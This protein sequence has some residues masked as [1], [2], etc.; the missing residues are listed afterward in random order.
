MSIVADTLNRLQARSQALKSR[1]PDTP[2][3]LGPH[4]DSGRPSY[5]ALQAYK[6]FLFVTIGSPPDSLSVWAD[7]VSQGFGLDGM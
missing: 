1:P 6:H 2:G 3:T 5:N 7:L 4:H